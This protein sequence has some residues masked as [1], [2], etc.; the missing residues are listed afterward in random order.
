M[1]ASGLVKPI[2]PTS[3]VGL[4]DDLTYNYSRKGGLAGKIIVTIVDIGYISHAEADTYDDNSHA[5][6][7]GTHS[8]QYNYLNLPKSITTDEGVMS[9]EYAANGQKVCQSSSEELRYYSIGAEY[10][11]GKIDA[12]HLSEARLSYTDGTTRLECVIRDHL[13]NTRV[14]FRDLDGD[15]EVNPRA[16]EGEIVQDNHYY[17]FGLSMNNPDYTTS[18]DPENRY[19]YNDEQLISQRRCL[20][21][22]EGREPQSGWVGWHI[23]KLGIGLLDY[24]A[25][26]YDP[27]IARFTTTDLLAEDFA[28]WSPY[29]YTF[30][31]PI[32]FTDPRGMAPDDIILRGSNNSSITIK[33][34][35]VDIDVNAGGIV[36]D[37]GGNYTFEGDDILVAGLDIAGV[38][39]P[40]GIADVAAAGIEAKKGNYGMAALS[41][42]GVIV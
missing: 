3:G 4:S 21:D 31:N 39:D 35:L 8:L 17:P 34:D 37:L 1:I 18:A 15:G 13:G 27:A 23:S 20:K 32:R 11:N 41:A 12:M 29:A 30:N 7:S 22:I 25:R 10:K 2:L 28:S 38:V 33:T 16:S 14:T 9:I 36:G 40:A 5:L 42:L 26:W 19:Q 6:T 24:G